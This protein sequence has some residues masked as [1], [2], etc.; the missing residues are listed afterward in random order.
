MTSRPLLQ[1]K[2][3][4]VAQLEVESNWILQERVQLCKGRLH[5]G[6][7]A[8]DSIRKNFEDVSLDMV[9]MLFWVQ[10]LFPYN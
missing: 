1:T 3:F 6:L 10:Q 4:K 2:A 9:T 8:S 7:R 5:V